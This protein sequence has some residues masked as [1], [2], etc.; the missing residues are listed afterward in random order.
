ML[1]EASFVSVQA[2]LPAPIVFQRREGT[3]PAAELDERAPHGTRDMH[4]GEAAPP[5]YQEPPGHHKGHKAEVDQNC[6]V[7]EKTVERGVHVLPEHPSIV[8]GGARTLTT[9]KT[10]LGSHSADTVTDFRT[11][12][13]TDRVAVILVGKT[14]AH[15]EILEP[16]GKGGM[17]EVYR[18]RD[19]KLDRDVAIKVLPED[20]SADPDRL[21]RLE[22][23]AK[24]LAALNHPHIATIHSLEEA[25]GARFL[26]L[27]LIRG[28]SLGQL[29]ATGPLPVEKAL[30]V[31]KQIAEALE[32]AHAE[33][34]IHRDLKP[35][36]VLV[37]PDGRA[38]VLDFGIAKSMQVDA[39]VAG[40]AQAT[41]LT[42]AG[43]L[44]G[45]PSYMSPEQVRGETIDKRVDI[46]AFGCLLFETLT[47]RSAFGRETL[48]DTL[49]AIV[50]QEP[51]WG[52]LPHAAPLQL[53]HLIK[54]CLRKD[55]Q[56][57][58]RDIGDA[59]IDISDD[60]D[61]VDATPGVGV[62]VSLGRRVLPWGL[63]AGSL[64]LAAWALLQTPPQA[65]QPPQPV[66]R[67]SV[68]L[69]AGLPAAL[70]ESM[71]L[72]VGRRSIAVS[73][74]GNDVVYVAKTD[75]TTLLYHRRINDATNTRIEGTEGAFHPF[76]SPDGEWVAFL[77]EN[78]VKKV[79]L[80]G[81]LPETLAEARS[82]LGGTWRS[83]HT[84]I[85]SQDWSGSLSRVSDDGTAFELDLAP[86]GH[87]WPNDLPQAEALLVT[88][89]FPYS[90]SIAV[91]PLD[92]GPERI[93]IENGADARYVS[94][95]HIVFARRGQLLA[96]PFDLQTLRVTGDITPVLDGVRTENR[97]AAQFDISRDGSLFYLSGGAANESVPVWVRRDGSG[98][99]PVGL[100]S[101]IY[102]P[103]QLSPD[104][105]RLAIVEVG[106]EAD[107]YIYDLASLQRQRLVLQG[108]NTNPVW[109]RDGSWLYY[110]SSG[111]DVGT[112]RVRSDG[113]SQPELLSEDGGA[114]HATSIGDQQ[115]LV[116]RENDIWELSLSGDG[117]AR[118]IIQGRG[119]QG[120]FSASPD[121]RWIAYTSD[122][123][124]T[125]QVY[126]Q[127][128][129]PTGER[130][131]VS[132][133]GGEEPLWS[134][135]GDELF[136]RYGAQWFA[137]SVTT[138]PQLQVGTPTEIF[139]GNYVN[140]PGYSYDIHPDGRFLVLEGLQVSPPSEINVILNWFEE[141]KQRVPTGR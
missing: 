86:G 73:P 41:N 15:Y 47:G 16:L 99:E 21:A 117:E 125:S 45:T 65:P 6:Q 116:S 141:L 121:G 20:L 94:T 35:A 127:P 120:L 22:R 30:E 118:P 134:F 33:G 42:V 7:G 102:G 55:R 28:E 129:P 140:V 132:I 104:G 31:C 83:D 105:A 97:G 98:K 17:G 54:R 89:G 14:L 34:I 49:A 53:R 124:G 100:S 107:L 66:R 19:T 5:E 110:V 119:D 123:E 48:A 8:V 131:R 23:E 128:Y 76:F 18:A 29:L 60:L 44:V 114:P 62:G 130:V 139:S 85:F 126:V 84:I 96:A 111:Q 72:R 77:T 27:E 24:L 69:P 12:S 138:E 92:G 109:S 67:L 56:R 93:V 57:R 2:G 103:F 39:E 81:G 82:A 70:G 36:N 79:S 88:V 1:D 91:L 106:L 59:W 78:A 80:R 68:T 43:T 74:D 63:A 26:V 4:P 61:D 10:T 112:F 135:R 87:E 108:D 101:G 137:A 3:D 122:E 90:P 136:F 50:D 40:T 13:A 9:A 133:G 115:L 38:K 113:V 52:A 75:E 58:L 25:E 71:P 64:A 95:G 46:W 37:T 32:A 11:A 51:D